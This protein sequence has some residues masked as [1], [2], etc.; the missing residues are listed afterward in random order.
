MNSKITDAQMASMV[1]E[2][3]GV[4]MSPS[5]ARRERNR[6]KYVHRPPRFK[7]ELTK[8]QKQLRFEFC[9]WVLDNED[10]IPNI[11]FS[12][13][14]RFER[15]PDNSWRRIK[16]GVMDESIFVDKKKYPESVMIWGAIGIG[17]KSELMKCSS[18]MDAD[19]YCRILEDSRLLDKLND[20]HGKG[21]WSFMHDG[22]PCHQA[23][24]TTEFLAARRVVVVPG[25]PP[26][27]PDLNPIEMIWSIM[28]RRIQ[29]RW[30]AGDPI[31]QLALVWQHLVDEMIDGLVRS[32]RDRCK[33]VYDLGGASATAYLSSHKQAPPERQQP[34]GSEWTDDQDAALVALHE[35]LG[36][37]WRQIA[38]R[39]SSTPVAV[40]YH[41]R[42]IKQIE[43]NAEHQNYE[44]LPSID[45]WLP[46]CLR[47]QRVGRI[48]SVVHSR[49][50]RVSHWSIMG[51]FL[52]KHSEKIECEISL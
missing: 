3:F 19:E 24:R 29:G 52:S 30:E 18:G 38:G 41:L 28:K 34:P 5:S 10:K 25:W 8:D 22:A 20:C 43:M 26:N 40:R 47:A 7:Q 11:V 48:P 14:S 23:Q 17:F 49:R 39:L 45:S 32:F 21:K 9:K 6:L 36:P 33:L 42:R 31:Q 35:S 15:G 4:R 12:D 1:T 27:S 2:R 13:E 16:R 51:C 44:L 46:E 50:G 37:R